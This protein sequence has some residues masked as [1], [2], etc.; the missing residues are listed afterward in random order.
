MKGV[1]VVNRYLYQNSSLLLQCLAW[2][3]YREGSGDRN[4][5]AKTGT[6]VDPLFL[7]FLDL[8]KTYYNLDWGRLLQILE[9]YR[10]GPKL[11]ILLAVFW[12]QQEVVTLHNGFHSSNLQATGGTTQGVLVSPTLFNVAV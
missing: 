9:G 12:L 5:G 8:V 6:R 1:G 10:S 11:H 3:F 7:V 4:S 2:F